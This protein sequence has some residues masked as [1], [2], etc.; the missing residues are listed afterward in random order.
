[1]SDTP[2]IEARS[3]TVSVP[4]RGGLPFVSRPGLDILVDLSLVIYPGEI[5]CMVGESGSASPHSAGHWSG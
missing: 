5:V 4:G 1:M 3:L 2:V